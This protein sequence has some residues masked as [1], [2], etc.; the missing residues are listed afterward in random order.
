MVLPAAWAQTF[1]WTGATDGNW[2]QAGNWSEGALTGSNTT[3]VI[4]GSSGRL[5]TVS[6]IGGGLTLNSLTFTSAA[7]GYTVSGL[8]PLIFSGLAPTLSSFS[9]DD[10]DVLI[11]API[12][13]ASTLT[14]AGDAGDFLGQLKFNGGISGAGSLELASG[15]GI[16]LGA[17]TYSGGTTVSGGL[18]A[19]T[20]G[21]GLGTGAVVIN[22]GSLQLQN[23]ITVTRALTISGAGAEGLATLNSSS[24]NNTWSGAVTLAGDSRIGSFVSVGAGYA[25]LRLSGPIELGGHTLTVN[26]QTNSLT[27]LE[28]VISGSGALLKTGAG[29]LTLTGD[30]NTFTGNIRVE[31]GTLSLGSGSDPLGSLANTLTLVAGTTLASANGVPLG[32]RSVVLEGTGFVTAAS[33]SFTTYAANLSGT[34]GL[35]LSGGNFELTGTN[36]FSGGLKIGTGVGGGVLTFTEGTSLGAVGNVITLDAGSI[37]FMPAASTFTVGTARPLEVTA[38]GG[39]FAAEAG[40]T[41]TIDAAISGAGKLTL[42]G[43]LDNVNGG[44]FV[45]AGTNTHSGGILVSRSTLAVGSDAVLGDAS[46]VLDLANATLRATASFT[47]AATRSTTISGNGTVDTQGFNLTFGQPIAGSGQLIKTGSGLLTLAGTSTASPSIILSEGSMATTAVNALGTGTVNL[48]S[49]TT[50]SLNA[51][52]QLHSFSGSGSLVTPAGRTLTLTGSSHYY[53]GALSGGGLIVLDGSGASYGASSTPEANF[54]LR[55]GQIL[56]T[57]DL[58]L[59]GAHSLE[60]T[61]AGGRLAAL[62]YRTLTVDSVISGGGVLTVVS[63]NSDFSPSND[64]TVVLTGANTFSGGTVI[65]GGS[66][67]VS[68]NAA[69]GT[70]AITLQGGNLVASGAR[71]FAQAVTVNAPSSYYVS[72]LSG[73]AMTFAGNWTLTGNRE[74]SVENTTTINGGL[75]GG[76]VAFTKSGSGSLLINGASTIT[77]DV[78]VQS[79]SLGGNGSY[80][81]NLAVQSYATIAPGMSAGLISVTGDLTLMGQSFTEMEIGGLTRGVG[82]YDAFDVGGS[83]LAGGTLTLSLINDFVPTGGETFLLFTAL[84]FGGAYDEINLPALGS[85]LSWNTNQLAATGLLTVSG[86]A[87]P[88]PSTYAAWAGALVL[89]GALIKRRRVRS[90]ERK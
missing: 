84:N 32:A 9:T 15:V 25:S 86:S 59:G 27:T 12:Q 29:T 36:T 57:S 2:S 37:N 48:S 44:T 52:Q 71:S 7:G 72:R 35:V 31:L 38:A 47:I 73:D 88:E 56:A 69:L 75:T 68:A 76:A 66:L 53:Y 14:V 82:G 87:I 8:A 5:A 10:A 13:I 46:G 39:T 51:D 67:M 33:S 6:D 78:I 24:G 16:I 45:L 60:V 58:T 83:F 42:R 61:A 26:A 17:N 40:K 20:N 49:G 4:F 22:G 50:L 54:S 80:A 3:A 34:A 64:G 30:E 55:G 19:I 11:S 85:G 89:V 90:G 43:V 81:G 77:G 70:G 18:F 41:V 21:N 23:D 74:V 1:T 65:A 28:G 63:Y 62:D 79:G